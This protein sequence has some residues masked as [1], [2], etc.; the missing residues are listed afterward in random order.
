MPDPSEQSD[1]EW[2]EWPQEWGVEGD[3]EDELVP[4]FE[5]PKPRK[6]RRLAPLIVQV[7]LTLVAIATFG[8]IFLAWRRDADSTTALTAFVGILVVILLLMVV[9]YGPV[10]N[11]LFG[12][13]VP[14]SLPMSMD[15]DNYIVGCPGCGTVFTVT[16]TEIE[17]GQFSCHNC[18]RNGHVRDH[19]L[20]SATIREEV[21]NS[22]GNLYHEWK[23]HSECPICHTMNAY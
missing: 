21:C 9:F 3:S 4:I 16:P 22:C 8:A 2:S 1:T 13:R 15:D 20:D 10:F 18:G 7:V 17:V 11:A 12:R 19:D 6:Q 23:E 14:R 5:D